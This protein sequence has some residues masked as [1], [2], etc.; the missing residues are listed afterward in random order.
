[1]TAK[2]KRTT[3]AQRARQEDGEAQRAA[4]PSEEEASHPSHA[5][6]EAHRGEGTPAPARPQEPA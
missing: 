2:K 1:M 4:R 3:P 5:S 6:E